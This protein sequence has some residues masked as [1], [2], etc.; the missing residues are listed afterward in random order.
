MPKPMVQ[1]RCPARRAAMVT[2]IAAEDIR[3]ST[4]VA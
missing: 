3:T 2:A 1:L 4:P